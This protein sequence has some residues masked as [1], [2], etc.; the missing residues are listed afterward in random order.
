MRM[1]AKR[2]GGYGAGTS[3]WRHLTAIRPQHGLK[4]VDLPDVNDPTP[5]G[6]PVARLIYS[7]KTDRRY[8]KLLTSGSHDPNAPP[9]SIDFGAQ[10]HGPARCG[11]AAFR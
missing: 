6:N 5:N 3:L 8:F 11:R 9:E 1:G 2:R 4:V 7:N 10:C